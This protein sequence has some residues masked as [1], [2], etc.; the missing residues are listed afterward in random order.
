MFAFAVFC[1][2]NKAELWFDMQL[3]VLLCGLEGLARVSP[4]LLEW[5]LKVATRQLHL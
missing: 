1:P 4:K 5:L 2:K 3:S